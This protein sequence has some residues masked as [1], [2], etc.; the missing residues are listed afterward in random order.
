MQQ[1]GDLFHRA[2]PLLR[3]LATYTLDTVGCVCQTQVALPRGDHQCLPLLQLSMQY[4]RADV[5]CWIPFPVHGE[6]CLQHLHAELTE[7]LAGSIIGALTPSNLDLFWADVT[8]ASTLSTV[9]LLWS[10]CLS[11]RT[12]VASFGGA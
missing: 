9:P 11:C 5:P 2:Q 4:H 8:L 12:D 3:L 7:E 6:T 10:S 1:H